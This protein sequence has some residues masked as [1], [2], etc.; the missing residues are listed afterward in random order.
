MVS[1]NEIEKAEPE[2]AAKVTFAP[3]NAHPAPERHDGPS[4][5]SGGAVVASGGYS[6]K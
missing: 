2:F 4:R 6:R 1:W 5:S 3:R